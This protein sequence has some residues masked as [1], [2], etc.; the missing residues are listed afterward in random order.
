MLPSTRPLRYTYLDWVLKHLFEY[1]K[2]NAYRKA[3]KLQ[4]ICLPS[5]E[6]NSIRRT[7]NPRP[8]QCGLGYVA[9]KFP[10]RG[11]KD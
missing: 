1:S 6:T 5:S 7:R 4:G 9:S 10:K 2:S 8:E 3:R 11:R